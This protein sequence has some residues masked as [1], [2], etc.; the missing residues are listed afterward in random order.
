[1]CAE[2]CTVK[3]FARVAWGK[4]PALTTGCRSQHKEGQVL[5]QTPGCHV[6]PE[7]TVTATGRLIVLPEMESSVTSSGDGDH[8]ITPADGTHSV[9]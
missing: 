9:F 8:M 5:R 3:V 1:M 6:C 2:Q 4:R 7:D